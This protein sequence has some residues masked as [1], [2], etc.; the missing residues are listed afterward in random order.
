MDRLHHTFANEDERENPEVDMETFL[1]T[2]LEENPEVTH[3][4]TFAD[5][6]L[7]TRDRG[8]VVR[9]KGGPSGPAAGRKFQITIQEDRRHR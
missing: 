8:L 4:E 9:L 2:L 7:L 1:T 5:A 6:G 3:V